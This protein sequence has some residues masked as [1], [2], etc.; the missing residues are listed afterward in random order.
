[1]SQSVPYDEIKIYR[2]FISEDILN[3]PDD[4]GVG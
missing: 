2:N 1:M 4:S 3:T